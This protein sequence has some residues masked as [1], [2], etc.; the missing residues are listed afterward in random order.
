M[1]FMILIMH[2][3]QHIYGTVHYQLEVQTLKDS[4]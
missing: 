4:T 3:S 2:Y 1:I